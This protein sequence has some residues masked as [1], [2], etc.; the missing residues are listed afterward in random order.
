MTKRVMIH[1]VKGLAMLYAAI[2]QKAVIVGC[3]IRAPDGD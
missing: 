1:L 2:L 3:R